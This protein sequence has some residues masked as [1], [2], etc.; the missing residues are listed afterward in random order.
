MSEIEKTPEVFKMQRVAEISD[1]VTLLLPYDIQAAAE[2]QERE[3]NDYLLNREVAAISEQER[4]S[5]VIAGAASRAVENEA[6]SL[7]EARQ[8]VDE[9]FSDVKNV[10]RSFMK[11]FGN[12]N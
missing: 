8:A 2:E 10:S 6:N 3:V 5:S 7:D 1:G 12:A 4:N 11:D 9:S